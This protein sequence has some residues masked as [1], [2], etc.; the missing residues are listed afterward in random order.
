MTTG[1]VYGVSG[2]MFVGAITDVAGTGG[3]EIKGIEGRRF[4]MDTG[5][6]LE[7]TKDGNHHGVIKKIN[8]PGLLDVPMHDVDDLAMQEILRPFW[9]ST[10]IKP[11]AG[12]G[13]YMKLPSTSILI[14]PMASVDGAGNAIKAIY[15]KAAKLSPDSQTIYNFSLDGPPLPGITQFVATSEQGDGDK[16]PFMIDTPAK[17]TAEYF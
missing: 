7:A 15:I 11:S 6:V 12:V 9:D 14:L 3:E 17:I 1:M 16:E 4:T 8:G 2:K 10:G 5:F 13:N